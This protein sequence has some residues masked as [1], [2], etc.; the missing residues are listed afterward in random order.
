MPEFPVPAG[1]AKSIPSSAL[2]LS[3]NTRNASSI[4]SASRTQ[5][6]PIV[7][8]RRAVMDGNLM[9]ALWQRNA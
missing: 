4:S 3:L 5:S 8:H 6:S 7:I 1:V 2:S 9:S